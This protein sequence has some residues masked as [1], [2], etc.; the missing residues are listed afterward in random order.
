MPLNLALAV[1]ETVTGHRL[2]ALERGGGGS[3]FQCIHEGVGKLIL[4]L[5]NGICSRAGQP[6]EKHSRRG[7]LT[8]HP[9]Q[10]G[11]EKD[12]H[13]HHLGC[14]DNTQPSHHLQRG[15]THMATKGACLP[16]AAGLP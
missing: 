7:Q 4:L 8:C 2:G 13:H 3:P 10:S 14:N 12:H 11:R 9:C 5:A 16:L 15:Y 1:W 6:K